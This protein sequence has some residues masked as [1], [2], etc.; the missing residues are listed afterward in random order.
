[1]KRIV[2]LGLMGFVACILSARADIIPSFMGTSAS[3]S[4]TIWSY[5]AN[6]TDQQNANTGDFFTIYDFGP[7]VASSATQPMGWT[8]TSSFLGTTPAKINPTDSPSILNLTWTYSGA[9]II[10]ASAA[11][12]GIGPFSVTVLGRVTLQQRSEFAAQ[13]T[14][15]TGPTAGTKVGNVGNISVPQPIQP[16]PEPATLA[17]FAVTGSLF[18][19]GRTVARRRK[20]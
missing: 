18:L 10:G 19:I 3:G 1:M 4:D 6:V 20:A 8:F 15:A 9:T 13:G 14:L 17:L 7:F 2:A 11:G 16:I 5:T 12:K